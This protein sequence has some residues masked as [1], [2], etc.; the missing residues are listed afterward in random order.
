MRQKSDEGLMD[1]G[2]K[3]S[4]NAATV[5]SSPTI[6][7]KTDRAASFADRIGPTYIIHRRATLLKNSVAP[8]NTRYGKNTKKESNPNPAG[9]VIR[10]YRTTS[11]ANKMTISETV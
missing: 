4:F 11:N 9:M 10:K 8:G 1:G 7:P 2:Q 5:K 6:I 3:T